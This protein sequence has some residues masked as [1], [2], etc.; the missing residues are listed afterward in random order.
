MLMQQSAQL[1]ATD[2]GEAS[3]PR[4]YAATGSVDEPPLRPAAPPEPLEAILRRLSKRIHG[5][6]AGHSI[7]PQDREDVLQRTLLRF[8]ETRE[9]I[10]NPDAWLLTVLARQCLMYHRSRRAHRRLFDDEADLDMFLEPGAQPT[11]DQRLDLARALRSLSPQQRR[12][13]ILYAVFEYS[14]ERA[15]ALS[16]YS[17]S[18]G[19]RILSRLRPRLRRSLRHAGGGDSGHPVSS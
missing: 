9:P 10:R 18:A 19:R 14:G 16:G 8:V 11:V 4:P 15:A 17:P 6:L 5:I 1:A 2:S 12:L 13:L 3:S 7:P